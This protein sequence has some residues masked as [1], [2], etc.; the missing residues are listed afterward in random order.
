MGQTLNAVEFYKKDCER[1]GAHNRFFM[2]V[3]KLELV[4]KV[5]VGFC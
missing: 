1:I 4:L 3:V 2:E 5:W